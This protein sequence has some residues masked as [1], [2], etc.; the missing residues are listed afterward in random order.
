MK[1]GGI[2]A[3]RGIGFGGFSLESEKPDAHDAFTV[4]DRVSITDHVS[5]F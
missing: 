5:M 1:F 3:G 4:H 2:G